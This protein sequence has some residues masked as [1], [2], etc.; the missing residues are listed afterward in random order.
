MTYY[1]VVQSDSGPTIA[2]LSL[3]SAAATCRPNCAND[4]RLRASALL[5][6]WLENNEPMGWGPVD[7]R[8]VYKVGEVTEATGLNDDPSI[9]S[10]EG[11]HLFGER[12]DAADWMETANI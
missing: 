3:P 7:G 4:S 12:K 2:H 1:K 11:L 9:V 8:T 10:G 6:E 5:V